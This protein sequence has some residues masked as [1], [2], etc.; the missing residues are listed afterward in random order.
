M[1]ECLKLRANPRSMSITCTKSF[2]NP[3]R[4]VIRV[5]TKM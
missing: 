1:G 2:L 3:N 5:S 4:S